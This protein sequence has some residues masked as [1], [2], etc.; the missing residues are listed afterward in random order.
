MSAASE[1]KRGTDLVILR[2]RNEPVFEFSVE[3]RDL[4][5]GTFFDG[6]LRHFIF[7]STDLDMGAGTNVGMQPLDVVYPLVGK[8]KRIKRT[9][10]PERFSRQTGQAGERPVGIFSI[11][12]LQQLALKKCPGRISSG[13]K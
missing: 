10:S 13:N 11:M 8:S 3:A 7:E 4:F 6:D 1:G 12:V 2:I 9:K 5:H